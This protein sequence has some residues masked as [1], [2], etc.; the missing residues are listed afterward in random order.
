LLG[1]LNAEP[2]KPELKA[3]Y[4][5]GF[6]DALHAGGK[7]DAFTFWDPV[8]TPGRRIDYIFVTPDLK[9]GAVNVIQVR[10]SDHLPVVAEIK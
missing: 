1:D 3:I 9:V 5:A 6:V 2:D 4:Q 8:P 7:D 10:A